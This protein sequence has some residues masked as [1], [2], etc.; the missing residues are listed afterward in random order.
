MPT[1]SPAL[2]T[3]L[4]ATDL[5]GYVVVR[6]GYRKMRVVGKDV[7]DGP[8]DY[9]SGDQF[10]RLQARLAVAAGARVDNH[11][12]YVVTLPDGSQLCLWFH[13]WRLAAGTD[14]APY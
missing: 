3:L 7:T 11:E 10:D 12:C 14:T 5:S 6:Y 9:T 13:D 2:T 1:L 4:G 8:L